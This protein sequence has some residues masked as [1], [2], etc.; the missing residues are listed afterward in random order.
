MQVFRQ[1]D[2]LNPRPWS[3]SKRSAFSQVSRHCFFHHLVLDTFACS[4]A[5]RSSAGLAATPTW[6][7]VA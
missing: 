5:V 2:G 1:S 6:K 3:R 7:V 4:R